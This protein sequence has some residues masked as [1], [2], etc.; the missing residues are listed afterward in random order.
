MAGREVS[1]AALGTIFAGSVFV[2]AGIKGIDIGAAIQS[3]VSG[4]SPGKLANTSPIIFGGT[5]ATTQS[6]SGGPG[7]VLTGVGSPIDTKSTNPANRALGRVMAAAYGWGS[8]ADWAALDNGW[9][10]LESGW[11]NQIY[12]GGQVGGPFLPNVAYGIPQALG[13]GP[14]GAPYPAGNAGNP[15]GAGG[16]SSPGA[17]IAWGLFYIR[18]TYGSPSRVP[19][20][21]GSGSGYSG[22]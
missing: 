9:G 4:K 3:I 18:Q 2:Y 5:G 20:W 13:H 21:T 10:N 15:P 8:G 6:S 11:N 14:N 19:G 16:S 1:A 17:Q 22:Y 12:S 7:A